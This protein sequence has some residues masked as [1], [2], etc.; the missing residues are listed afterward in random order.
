MRN[1]I[2]LVIQT[3]QDMAVAAAS[4]VFIIICFLKQSDAFETNPNCWLGNEEFSVDLI[5]P[6]YTGTGEIFCCGE[7]HNR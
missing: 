4:I 7:S 6:E 1:L 3:S 5:C 2:L